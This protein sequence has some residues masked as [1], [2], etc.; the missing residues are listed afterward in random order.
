MTE[1]VIRGVAQVLCDVTVVQHFLNIIHVINSWNGR[2]VSYA[3]LGVNKSVL[4]A[5]CLETKFPAA[6]SKCF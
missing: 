4:V 5:S 1:E 6:E 2:L 3:L